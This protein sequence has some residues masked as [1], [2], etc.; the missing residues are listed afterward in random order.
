MSQIKLR[1]KGFDHALE[2]SKYTNYIYNMFY[3]F[4]LFLRKGGSPPALHQI[5]ATTL[6]S[7]VSKMSADQ[8]MLY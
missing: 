7:E 3:G 5:D 1:D 8:Y 4:S 6:L 2:K